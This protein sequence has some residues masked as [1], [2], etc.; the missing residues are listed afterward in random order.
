MQ[1]CVL[2]VRLLQSMH[3]QDQQIQALQSQFRRK[4]PKAID[5]LFFYNSTRVS[6]TYRISLKG[7]YQGIRFQTH[8]TQTTKISKM[9]KF[10]EVLKNFIS[11]VKWFVKYIFFLGTLSILRQHIFGL[12]LTHPASPYADAI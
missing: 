3:A 7:L 10:K 4:W 12:F 9:L 6:S 1:G 8:S 2:Q 5:F 11:E